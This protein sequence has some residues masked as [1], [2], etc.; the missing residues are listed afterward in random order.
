MLVAVP[1]CPSGTVSNSNSKSGSGAS[2][3]DLLIYKLVSW[4]E[5]DVLD[6]H[7]IVRRQKDLD[8]AYLKKWIAW[9][10]K[11]GIKGLTQRYAELSVA[12]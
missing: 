3:E 8:T 11:E 2:A 5:R 4:R 6:V 12:K 1:G 10:E 7:S 9:W